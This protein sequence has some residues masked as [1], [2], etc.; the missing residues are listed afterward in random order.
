[1]NQNNTQTA[2][3]EVNNTAMEALPNKEQTFVL[4][5]VTSNA[6]TG[7]AVGEQNSPLFYMK[8]AFSECFPSAQNTDYQF[9]IMP[10]GQ[11]PAPKSKRLIDFFTVGQQ[12]CE[13]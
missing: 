3:I 8:V 13:I 4:K 5:G 6:N 2:R 9:S 1:M 10:V 12:G 11:T 7:N